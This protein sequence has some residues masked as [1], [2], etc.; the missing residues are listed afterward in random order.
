MKRRVFIQNLFLA[1]G[2]L[3]LAGQPGYAAVVKKKKAIRG[4][5]TAQGKKLADVSVSDGFAVVRTDRK[6]RYELPVHPQA[7]FVFVSIPAGYH[8][9][10]E[11]GLARH[12]HSLAGDTARSFDFEL[13]PLETDDTR[14]QFIIWADPQVKNAADV[15]LMMQQSV[16]DVQQLVQGLGAG[17]LIHGIGVGDLVWDNHALF[18]KYSE[19]VSAMGIPFFQALGNHDMDY[20]QGGDDTS[21]STFQ[22][23]F[24]PTYYSFNRGKVHYVVL[25]DVRYLGREREYDGHISRQQ[26]DWLKEDLRYVPQDQL[27]ILNAHIPVARVKNR[28]DLYALL[29]GY[30]VHIM[31]GH[32]H[33]NQNVIQEG[34]YEHIH[35]TVCGAWWTGP[36][37]S[38]GAPS[39]YGVY[40]VDGNQLSWHYKSTG[41]DASHQVSVHVET[42]T[43]QHR[44]IA[45][46]WN[47]DPAWK[48]EWWA[49]ESYMGTLSN[50]KGMDPTAVALYK[51]TK[52]PAR[53]PFAEP[54]RTDHLFVGHFK[55]G[56][57]K[58]RIVATDRFGKKYEQLKEL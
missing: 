53:R 50:S 32:T 36:V 14:H 26:L 1:S 44:L 8:F 47:W 27:V 54:S 52:L 11:K 57:K 23:N 7:R 4:R 55:P 17:T 46:V 19:A 21:D 30:Q 34:I 2:G 13:S 9:P 18:P 28:A 22:K 20:R 43:N 51:G 48:V 38:D 5:V 56:V 33:Y 31:T 41:L 35:G 12:Y 58:V 3:V 49:D 6:G 40:E 24:G 16:P 45:N 10:N 39:G 37:C 42:L 29:Q 15:Q 25:D